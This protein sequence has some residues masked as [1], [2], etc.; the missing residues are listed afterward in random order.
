MGSY[1]TAGGI[2]NK[3]GNFS[4]CKALEAPNKRVMISPLNLR[5]GLTLHNTVN[6]GVN[7]TTLSNENN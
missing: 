5:A 6:T 3:L 7:T 2:D 1:R 4:S